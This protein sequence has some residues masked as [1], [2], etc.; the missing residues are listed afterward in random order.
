MEYANLGRLRYFFIHFWLRYNTS[1]T[2][3]KQ[4]INSIHNRNAKCDIHL[5]NKF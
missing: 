3:V 4:N 1:P 2:L 5:K